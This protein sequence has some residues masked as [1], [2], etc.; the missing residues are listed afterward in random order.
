M[1]MGCLVDNRA[2]RMVVSD[3]VRRFM[4]NHGVRP[5]HIASQFPV[6]VEM[7]FLVSPVD[8]HM[9]QIRKSSFASKHRRTG[10]VA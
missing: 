9:D 1:E 2:N 8:I 3:V 10:I 5:S 6:A 7:Y 4:K